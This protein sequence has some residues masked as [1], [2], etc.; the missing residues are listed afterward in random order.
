MRKFADKQ[1][2]NTEF[3]HWDHSISILCGYSREL[4]NLQTSKEQTDVS[5]TESTLILSGSSPDTRGSWP[6]SKS[7]IYFHLVKTDNRFYSVWVLIKKRF[8][9]PQRCRD[10]SK[11]YHGGAV[12]KHKVYEVRGRDGN[13]YSTNERY[14]TLIHFFRD[15]SLRKQIFKHITRYKTYWKE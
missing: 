6:I 2:K 13:G 12:V 15:P 14:S 1:T 7:R 8:S 11:S 3:K 4:A 5:K 9:G 10:L